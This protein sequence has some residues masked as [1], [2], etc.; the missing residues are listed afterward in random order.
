MSEDT[1]AKAL[2]NFTMDA[3]CGDAIRHLADKGHSPGQIR[4]MLTFPAPLDHIRK[5]MWDHFVSTRKVLTKDPKEALKDDGGC[6]YDM[7]ETRDSYGRRS[8]LRVKKESPEEMSVSPED[9]VLL[10]NNDEW[11]SQFPHPKGPVWVHR[12]ALLERQSPGG[13]VTDL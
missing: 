7:V 1:F 4:E 10:D 2:R 6:I 9:Y 11:L 5:V 12:S 3:A 8:F 13:K